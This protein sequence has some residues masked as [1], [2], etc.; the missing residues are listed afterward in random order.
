MWSPHFLGC[1]KLSKCVRVF[2]SKHRWGL[3]T[4]WFCKHSLATITTSKLHSLPLK[5]FRGFREFLWPLLFTPG[6][7][8]R[9]CTTSVERYGT[10]YE[11]EHKLC[12]Q[13]NNKCNGWEASCFVGVKIYFNTSYN[14]KLWIIDGEDEKVQFCCEIQAIFN[15]LK[16]LELLPFFDTLY[17]W[18][19]VWI[20]QIGSPSD[21]EF[22]C[23]LWLCKSFSCLTKLWLS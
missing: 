4:I 18:N 8:T 10:N 23:W 13:R 16:I 7:D 1:W 6:K 3:G 22:V 15:V 20:Y 21:I 5:L 14:W 12:F 11:A 9:L 19:F 17:I 2:K